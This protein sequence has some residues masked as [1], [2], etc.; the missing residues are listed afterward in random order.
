MLDFEKKRRDRER[1][2]RLDHD[3]V[4]LID[5]IRSDYRLGFLF[6]CFLGYDCPE[7][8]LIKVLDRIISTKILFIQL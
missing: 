7:R 2:N 1:G 8:F 3:E 6:F 4:L 5:E